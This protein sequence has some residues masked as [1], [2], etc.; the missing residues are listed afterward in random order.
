MSELP[1]GS[2]RLASVD[3]LRG[4]ASLA[5]V[6][7]HGGTMFPLASN[8]P[9]WYVALYRFLE[10]GHWGVPLF[11]VVSG[12]CIHMTWAKQMARTGQGKFE[13]YPFWKRR[14]H[15]L[16]P[17][18]FV[19]LCLSMLMIVGA[20]YLRMDVKQVSAVYPEP[21]PRWMA[22]DFVLHSTMLHGL[23]AR[24]DSGG[25]NP[26][27][28][29][30]AREEYYYLLYPLL[31]FLRRKFGAAP[32]IAS[33]LV[34]SA[35]MDFVYVH[36][37]W[38]PRAFFTL[39][40]WAQWVLGMVAVEAYC[41]VIKIP[42]WCRSIWLGIPLAALTMWA[43]KGWPSGYPL[44][45]A[46]SFFVLLNACV[47]L[48]K[49]G[50]WPNNR[51]LNWFSKVGVFSYSLYLIHHPIRAVG[52][53]LL[54]RLHLPPTLFYHSLES[55]V[56]IVAGFYGGK[57]FFNLVERHFLN[58]PAKPVRQRSEPAMTTFAVQNSAAAASD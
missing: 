24:F 39:V 12:F 4:M 15:R 21:I 30:L 2:K 57:A 53:T 54:D 32:T 19:T 52:K 8:A 55:A 44:L 16:Y 41:G 1:S 13:F 25:G 43:V 20:F 11:F 46:C 45:A 17:P 51:L 18:Y 31:L 40:L 27:F 37:G 42:A 7:L 47:A 10:T 28:W 48:E 23:S 9:F 36:H 49:A 50:R 14:L 6:L 58:T 26:P 35:V 22:V 34:L 38:G 56:V 5:V 33:V 3:A 29:S